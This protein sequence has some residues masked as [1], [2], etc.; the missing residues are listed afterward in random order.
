MYNL[1]DK[2][3]LLYEGRQIYFGNIHD[4]KAYFLALG[5]EC[6]DRANE[7]DFLTSLTKPQERQ[8]REGFHDRTPQ[9]PD[10]FASIW[11]HSRERK[12]LLEQISHY[13]AKMSASRAD[14]MAKFRFLHSS[15]KVAS[16]FR[17]AKSPY[18]TS[19]FLEIHLLLIRCARRIKQDAGT[20]IGATV[21]NIIVSV[22]LGSM[23]YN[24]DQTSNSFLGREVLIFFGVVLNSNVGAL[25]G[26]MLWEHR[27]I[28]EKHYRYGFYAPISEA[29]AS[30]I[31]DIPNK[32]VT[33][34]AV[35]TPYYFLANLR[36]TP[37][38]YFTFLLFAFM[39]IMVGSMIWRASG[40]MSRTLSES[41]PL[42]AAFSTL[43][44]IYTGFIIP[45]PY[46][47]P[48][49]RWFTYV[50]PCFYLFESLLVNEFSNRMFTCSSMVPRGI[51]YADSDP[52]SCTI[53][54]AAPGSN[55]IDGDAYLKIQYQYLPS[56]KWRNLGVVLAL[57]F[58]F[59]TVYLLATRYIALARSKGE[60]LVFKK[61]NRFHGN[62]LDP[63]KAHTLIS[64]DFGRGEKSPPGQRE[65]HMEE[66]SGKDINNATFMWEN[67]SLEVP[68]KKKGSKVILEDVRGWVEPGTLTALIGQTGAGKTSL[69]NVLAGRVSTGAVSGWV[70]VSPDYGYSGFEQKIGYAMQQDIHIPSATVREA[71]EFSALLRQPA[72][73]SRENK[74]AYVDTVI[75]LLELEPF[76][77]AVIGV[78]GEGLNVEQ[79]KRLTIGVELSARP[80]LLVFLDEPTSGLDSDT[81]WSI[82]M[83]LR[84]LADSG[85]AVL[86]TIHQP[87]SLV[88]EMFDNL[89]VLSKGKQV[90]FGG[91]GPQ[92]KTLI[93][94]FERGGATRCEPDQNPAEW[95]LSNLDSQI[96]D[97]PMRWFTSQ[98]RQR[99]IERTAV[100]KQNLV[101]LDLTGHDNG[102]YQTS[103]PFYNQLQIVTKRAMVHDWRTPNFLWSK[104]LTTF[105]VV[106]S[107][108][109]L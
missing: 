6:P 17:G 95:L 34:V 57:I 67:L 48:W 88:L 21:G 16:W 97:W 74:L 108:E 90:Y 13:E 70:G 29:V 15:G 5:F 44:T 92:S 3:L 25:E 28:V 10:D 40:A 50:N 2:V 1:M 96:V 69:L 45:I 31:A 9:T 61:R 54:G 8:I 79:R 12:D 71:L 32:L 64:H 55:L 73:Y 19:C 36:R 47:K 26:T 99:I 89:L 106:S 68:D 80:E 109:I 81:A 104:T 102:G 14:Q 100:M 24:L 4:A 72:N 39:A 103:A 49:L 75:E 86:C 63:E 22:I 7:P 59:G 56:H 83:L 18:M 41:M 46:M 27:P 77:D 11:H 98:E 52:K 84:K 42:G 66:K 85:Q 62:S 60:V 107:S 30:M 91:I 35:N 94:Y 43:L 76:A 87:S 33:T 20:L 23:F 105:L 101:P 93:E 51:G 65:P 38:A 37:E 53:Q 82:C 58:L 78:P